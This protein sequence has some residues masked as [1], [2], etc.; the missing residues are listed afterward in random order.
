MHF[1][2]Y[3]V[4][5]SLYCRQNSSAKSLNR[6]KTDTSNWCRIS[7][8]SIEQRIL[9][10][11][12]PEYLYNSYSQR[13]SAHTALGGYLWADLVSTGSWVFKTWN[14]SRVTFNADEFK[15]EFYAIIDYFGENGSFLHRR[16]KIENFCY[17]VANTSSMKASGN[18]V[19]G[20]ISRITPSCCAW[21]CTKPSIT[22]TAAIAT[23]K[24]S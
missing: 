2:W 18:M 8:C 17:E 24:I 10:P 16:R 1:T 12:G 14:E 19:S 23:E 13:I 21:I 6:Q 15:T 4:R 3:L 20:L 22:C 5:F 7:L 11:F 9:T